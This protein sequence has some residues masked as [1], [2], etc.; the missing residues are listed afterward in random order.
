[1]PDIAIILY[2]YI[3]CSLANIYEED[4]NLPMK[5]NDFTQGLIQSFQKLSDDV[6]I[7]TFEK[8]LNR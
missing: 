8:F 4:T 1:M 5:L 6:L 7:A 3:H 2:M